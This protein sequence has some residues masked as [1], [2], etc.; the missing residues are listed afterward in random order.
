MYFYSFLHVLTG[1]VSE[2]FSFGQ[3]K[4]NRNI[5]YSMNNSENLIAS[6]KK[7]KRVIVKGFGLSESSARK[8]A[9]KNGV[10]QVVGSFVDSDTI[11]KKKT[12]ISEEFFTKN[13]LFE[14]SIKDYSQG[15]IVFFKTLNIK[16]MVRF[17]K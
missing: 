14:E 17:M 2:V 11:Y 8:D 16:K 15:T 6:S 13:E 7:V 3:V 1:I 9:A 4:T 12:T 5:N 10:S